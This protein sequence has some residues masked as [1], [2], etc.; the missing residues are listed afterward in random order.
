MIGHINDPEVRQLVD[1]GLVVRYVTPKAIREVMAPASGLV[2]TPA[3]LPPGAEDEL[4][5]RLGQERWLVDQRGGVIRHNPEVR[6]A[7][8]SLMRLR[9]KEKF[10]ATNERAV[11]YFLSQAKRIEQH[12]PKRCIT[13]FCAIMPILHRWIKSGPR[14][15]VRFSPA[16]STI[17]PDKARPISRLDSE[18]AY[19][20]KILP[21][22]RRHRLVRY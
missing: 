3:E 7:M 20:R 13:C 2:K 19:D 8:L 17:L 16:P 18:G 4:F 21:R 5:R 1:P 6:S 11:Q 10:E 22:Y 9:N 12:A 15:W 14:I